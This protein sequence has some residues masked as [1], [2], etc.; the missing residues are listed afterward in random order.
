MKAN[1]QN[2]ISRNVS[3]GKEAM[4]MEIIKE[5]K[6]MSRIEALKKLQDK[7]GLSKPEA[8]EIITLYTKF[9]RAKTLAKR[10]NRNQKDA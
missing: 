9:H 1:H 2:Q 6:G 7:Y 10:R 8:D 3:K 5:I 4:G